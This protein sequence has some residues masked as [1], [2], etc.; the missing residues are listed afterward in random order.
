MIKLHTNYGTI[1]IELD[2]D[3]A[4]VTAQNFLEYVNSGHYDNTLFHRV[5]DGFMIQGGGF[6]PGMKQKKTLAPI[7][8]EAANGLKNDAYTIA[9]ARTSDVDSATSQFFINV[10][11]NSFLNYSAPTPQGF[12]Y[13][14]FGKVVEG[15]DVVDKI[16]QVKTGDYAGHQNVPL[17]DVVITKAESC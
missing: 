10:S 11:N 16:K 5:I 9:M 1:T 17:E 12:G 4:P 6:E 7:K 8:N 15:K 14:V 3:K 2:S 13:C